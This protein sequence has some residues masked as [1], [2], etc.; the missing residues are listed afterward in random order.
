MP[1]CSCHE[2]EG[3]RD[4]LPLLRAIC[5]KNVF[6]D[7]RKRSISKSNTLCGTGWKVLRI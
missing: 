5:R 3:I 6:R 1:C 7:Y 2:R 4:N